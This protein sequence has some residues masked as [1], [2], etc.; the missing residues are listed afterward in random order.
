[1]EKHN[2]KERLENMLNPVSTDPFVGYTKENYIT[3]IM[4]MAEA[5]NIVSSMI[6]DSKQ[7]VDKKDIYT[8]Y[9][10]R[11]SKRF[12]DKPYNLD[13]FETKLPTLEIDRV[14]EIHG[15]LWARV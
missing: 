11:V 8:L 15:K 6:K 1:M 13:S 9:E 10:T 3:D 7:T 5:S 4:I 12:I 14:K 2:Y